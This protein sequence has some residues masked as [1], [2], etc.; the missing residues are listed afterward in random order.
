MHLPGIKVGRWVE[1]L[2]S[3]D[4]NEKFDCVGR[5]KGDRGGLKDV[6]LCVYFVFAYIFA[7]FY[8]TASSHPEPDRLRRNTGSVLF[9]NTL[10]LS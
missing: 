7:F 1:R 2:G 6:R 10:K 8:L 3:V 9:Q 4:D 5:R